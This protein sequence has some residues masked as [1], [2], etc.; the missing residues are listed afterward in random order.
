[1]LFSVPEEC[2]VHYQCGTFH[3]PESPHLSSA[4]YLIPSQTTSE[5]TRSNHIQEVIILQEASKKKEITKRQK[6]P[7][8]I[9]STGTN[10][11]QEPFHGLQEN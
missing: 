11:S 5:Y 10:E 6:D 8:G 3:V 9:P 4:H 7:E 1:M 2:R